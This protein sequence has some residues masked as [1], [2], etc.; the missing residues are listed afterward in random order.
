MTEKINFMTTTIVT[1]VR[2]LYQNSLHLERIFMLDQIDDNS[3]DISKCFPMD[4]KFEL[5]IAR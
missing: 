5:F 3:D 4:L 1:I 2:V